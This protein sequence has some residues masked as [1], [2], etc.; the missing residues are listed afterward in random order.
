MA[1]A[2]PLILL[3]GM[4]CDAGLYAPQLPALA[5]RGAV[6]VAPCDT[7][8]TIAEIARAVLA[9][10]PARFALAGLSMGGIV[11]MELLAQAPERV[12]RLALIDTNP[13]A[14]SAKVQHGRAAQIARAEAGELDAMM[15]DTFLPA[16]AGDAPLP[17]AIHDICC[18]MARNLGAE[19]F[20]RQSLALRDRADRCAALRAYSGETLVLCGG[21]DRLCPPARHRL[22]AD[23]MPQARLKMLDGIGHL[24]TLE[25]P[26]ITTDILLTWL[27][28]A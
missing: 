5:A 28:T 24:P 3:P 15:R 1:Q 6:Q 18:D 22:I 10:A 2:L 17:A 21:A 13:L 16:Y 27:E 14:E 11:A 19:V 9:R 20:A 8:S 25:A 12:A 26:D 7:A 23:L 4:M